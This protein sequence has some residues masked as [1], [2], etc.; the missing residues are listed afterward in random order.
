MGPDI[1]DLYGRAIESCGA[2][3]LAIQDHQWSRPTPCAEW[4]VRALVNHVVG[5]NRWALPLFAGQTVA[6]VGDRLDGDLLGDD[7]VK[8][9]DE[10][11][12]EARDVVNRSG[13]M[14]T[15]VHLSFGDFTG[16]D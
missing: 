9:W 15:I 2:Y 13:A 1:R 10:S 12:G 8:S 4:D 6:D 16:E 3:V 7:P 5:E 14:E 11:A